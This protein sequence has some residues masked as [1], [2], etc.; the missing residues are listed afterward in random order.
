MITTEIPKTEIRWGIHVPIQ[1]YRP[2]ERETARDRAR[3]ALEKTQRELDRLRL[4]Q[5]VRK[6]LPF[7]IDPEEK[8]ELLK[9]EL[10]LDKHPESIPDSF[11]QRIGAAVKARLAKIPVPIERRS[12]QL[13]AQTRASAS[14]RIVSF[15]ASTDG[16]DRH[17]TKIL[18]MGIDTTRYEANP[19]VLFSHDGYGGFF[20]TPAAENILGRAIKLR[21]SEKRL[22]ADVEF[23]PA[24][25]N[26]KAEMVLGMIRAGVV[27]AISIG[28]IP[29]Q[30]VIEMEG[31]R[32]IPVIVKS[33]L[34]EL[35]V[36]PIPSNP[37]AL[38][39]GRAKSAAT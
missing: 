27:S 8:T 24:S 14:S 39:T 31:E 21:K 30:V 22:E 12:I 3:S 9:V 33:E 37:D 23:L 10:L 5:Q 1:E 29:K 32:E 11:V 2:F 25:I 15:V 34:L 20:T 28:F 35:S 26:P 13:V 17:G 36:V 6:L 19:I 7:A 16:L 4:L 18:P 38:A